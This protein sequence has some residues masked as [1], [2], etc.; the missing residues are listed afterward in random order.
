LTALFSRWR[1]ILIGALLGA[2]G[3]AVG[4]LLLPASWHLWFEAALVAWIGAIYIGFGLLSGTRSAII[5]IVGG[6]VMLLLAVSGGGSTPWLLPLALLL[7]AG[8]DAAH[9]DGRISKAVPRWYPSFCAAADLVL[10]GLYAG[11]HRG[12]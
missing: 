11:V 7:H 2:A 10:A 1:E 3:V 12:T 5:E 6:T 8:W 9:H 4:Q